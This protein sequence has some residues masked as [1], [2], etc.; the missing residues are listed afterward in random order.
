MSNK[1]CACPDCTKLRDNPFRSMDWS[2]LARL[3][4]ERR[5]DKER[6]VARVFTVLT[7]IVC[8]YVIGTAVLGSL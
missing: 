7:L 3:N 1:P 5:E 4:A 2:Y 6:R 8:A